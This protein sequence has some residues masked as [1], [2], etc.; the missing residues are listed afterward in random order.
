MPKTRREGETDRQTENRERDDGR[1][2]DRIY[3]RTSGCV[4]VCIQDYFIISSEEK[5]IYLYTHTLKK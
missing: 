2:I 3:L 4:R 5:K 1:G